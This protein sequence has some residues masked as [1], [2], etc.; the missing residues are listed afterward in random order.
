MKKHKG[1]TLIELVTAIVISTLVV[2]GLGS[3]LADNQR[4]WQMMYNRA[5][6]DVVAD[7]YTTRISFDRIVRKSSAQR[8]KLD[9]AGQ[10]VEIYYYQSSS[11]TEPDRFARFYTSGGQLL[12][13]FGDLDP[14]T[15][16]VLSTTS[17]QTLANNVTSAVFSVSGRNIQMV[18]NLDNGSETIMMT[19]SAI[20]YNE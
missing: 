10:Y 19:C 15:F 1:L 7:A 5:Y 2:I 16:D 9:L 8:Y 14:G 11:S 17:T 13:D 6:S 12:V 20:R 18:L 3:V 4:G